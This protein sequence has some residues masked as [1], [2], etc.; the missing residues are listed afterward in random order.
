MVF[1]AVLSKGRGPR[2]T[3]GESQSILKGYRSE[4][5]PGKTAVLEEQYSDQESRSGCDQGRFYG[6]C[7]NALLQSLFQGLCLRF[8]G[9]RRYTGDL[10]GIFCRMSRRSG[11]PHF[12]DAPFNNFDIP[13]YFINPDSEVERKICGKSC[14]RFAVD[15][16]T[17]DRR[18]QEKHSRP[19][20]E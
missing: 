5:R 15:P 4:E 17:V 18:K 1:G 10:A 9:R 13:Q 16:A 3:R 19:C 11:L 7:P 12:S 2:S 14:R 20:P 8:C 6:I